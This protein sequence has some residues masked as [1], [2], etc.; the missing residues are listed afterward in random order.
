MYVYIHIYIGG[1]GGWVQPRN[2]VQLWM[3]F[4]R[5][6]FGV[7]VF[8]ISS[9]G[10]SRKALNYWWPALG[11]ADCYRFPSHS[12]GSL[13]KPPLKPQHMLLMLYKTIVSGSVFRRLCQHANE[14]RWV[15]A[16][17]G[18]TKR[19]QVSPSEFQWVQV[20]PSES[21]QVS[22]SGSRWAQLNPSESK[23]VQVSPS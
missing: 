19:V 21:A 22:P 13:R 11:F 15:Q 2:V 5:L 18:D 17:P 3:S 8:Y 7:G 9:H 16:R 14:S 20:S 23:C 1:W 6:C 10:V 12:A 4:T